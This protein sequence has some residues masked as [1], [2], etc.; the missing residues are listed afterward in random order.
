MLS[1]LLVTLNI[2]VCISLIGVV[3]LQRSEGGAFGMGGGPTG[4]I[5]TRGAGDLLTR[6]TWIL[7]GLFL[8]LSMGLTLLSAHD[9]TSSSVIDQLAKERANPASLL[10]KASPPAAPTPAVP[11]P[12]PQG[13]P[14]LPPT[15]VPAPANAPLPKAMS[16][17]PAKLAHAP[18][19]KA[20]GAKPAA[21]EPA[22]TPTIAAP[23]PAE[24]APAEAPPTEA[25]PAP[26]APPVKLNL[27]PPEPKADP[28]APVTTGSP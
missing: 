15:A 28:N 5:T 26:A 4:L 2:L 6:T 18:I 24:A 21:A 16:L 23:P 25:A 10:Q 13:A 27:T 22:A 11:A 20:A 17:G 8:A 9:R 1:G 3:L 19:A 7:F 14:L 12:T